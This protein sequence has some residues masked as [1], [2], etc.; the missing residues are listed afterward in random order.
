MII[1]I[2]ELIGPTAA[3]LTTCSFMP[4]VYRSW[5]T[6]STE[7]LSWSMLFISI[8]AAALWFAYGNYINDKIIVFSNLIMGILQLTLLYFKCMFRNQ[9][10]TVSD[11]KN[12]HNKAF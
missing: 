9:T 11:H 6:K 10:V 12:K 1:H 8:I 2:Q 7:S 4:Q 5:K 3:L